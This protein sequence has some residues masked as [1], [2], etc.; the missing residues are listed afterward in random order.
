MH[1]TQTNRRQ[2]VMNSADRAVTKTS[3]CHHITPIL[4]SLNWLK[5][6]PELENQIMVF[7]VTHINL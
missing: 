7:T 6:E 1:V 2:L 3:K 4:K 5:I